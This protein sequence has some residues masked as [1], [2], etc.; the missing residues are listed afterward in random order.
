MKHIRKFSISLLALA[1]LALSGTTTATA[2]TSD[3]SSA[4]FGSSSVAAPTELDRSQANLIAAYEDWIR[5]RN[6]IRRADLDRFARD[7]A[8][9]SLEETWSY[10]RDPSDLYITEGYDDWGNGIQIIRYTGEQADYWAAG[11][12]MSILDPEYTG[13]MGLAAS[14]DGEFIYIVFFT[15]ADYG[16]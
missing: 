15:E 6:I 16:Y 13:P 5:A 1:A 3:L 9:L 4:L 12:L 7:Y 8:E 14:N 11:D 10:Y 2:Q